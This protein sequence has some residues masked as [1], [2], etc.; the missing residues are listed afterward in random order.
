MEAFERFAY[1]D[2]T[3]NEE[4]DTHTNTQ[5]GGTDIPDTLIWIGGSENLHHSCLPSCAIINF[6]CMDMVLSDT[7]EVAFPYLPSSAAL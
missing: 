5:C 1:F 4:T 7:W 2:C 6:P 3:W